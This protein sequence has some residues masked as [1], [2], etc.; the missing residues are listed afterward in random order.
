MV[1][2][3]RL[4]H[5]LPLARL[6]YRDRSS[7][8]RCCDWRRRH[9]TSIDFTSESL[10]FEI[11]SPSNIKQMLNEQLAEATSTMSKYIADGLMP[12][13]PIQGYDW[14]EGVA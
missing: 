10:Y 12:L 14:K 11:S 3:K 4:P 2:A 5:L 7:I 13:R 6:R 9:A 8:K 1:T